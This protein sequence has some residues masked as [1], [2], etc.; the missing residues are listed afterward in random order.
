MLS[1]QRLWPAW[2]S[3]SVGFMLILQCLCDVLPCRVRGGPVPGGD[4]AR[5][6]L[7]TEHAQGRRAEREQSP[8]I[9]RE[10]EPARGQY[11]QHV[12][13][14]EE[15]GVAAGG[16]RSID[17]PPRA[18]GHLLDRLAAGYWPGPDC[19]VGNLLPDVG[20][21]APL[22][23]AVVPLPEIVGDD[24]G[25]GVSR[26][27][28]GLAGPPERARQHEGKRAP[29]EE[30]PERLGLAFAVRGERNVRSPRVLT[31]GRPLRL[32]M[33]H[34]PDL[35]CL[36]HWGRSPPDDASLRVAPAGRPRAAPTSAAHTRDTGWPSQ[37]RGRPRPR[38]L[39]P[40]LLARTGSSRHG[41]PTRAGARRVPGSRPWDDASAPAPPA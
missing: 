12:P 1:S 35:M 13:V 41:P 39:P 36:R 29:A 15:G 28:T 18:P 7:V 14:G 23:V 25:V 22:V 27:A 21:L 6:A 32:A 34:Q 5:L 37:G 30:P 38:P 4:D 26:E 20:R 10:P 40:R 31:R 11:P 24:R 9:G 3:C 2:R 8:S 19:P 17:H 16:H 33:P